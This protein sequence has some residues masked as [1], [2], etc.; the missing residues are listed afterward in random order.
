MIL[1]Q[2]YWFGQI[3][4]QNSNVPNVYEF[5]HSELTEYIKFVQVIWNSKLDP[6]FQI[7]TDLVPRFKYNLIFMKFGIQR[8]QNTLILNIL[9][10]NY[11]LVPNFGPTIK[12]L[13]NFMKFGI[14]NKWNILIDI[15]CL[16]SRQ[17]S[18]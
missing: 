9:F 15:Q 16:D 3:C 5:R 8:R 13:S 4:S 1:T 17:I 14:K 12:V 2:N 6:K 18:F 11:D 10:G 7:W